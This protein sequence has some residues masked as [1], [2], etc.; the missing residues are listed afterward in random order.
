[1]NE[2]ALAHLGAVGPNKRKERKKISLPVLITDMTF[3]FRNVSSMF[4]ASFRQ[5]TVSNV[6]ALPTRTSKFSS[7]CDFLN[8]HTTS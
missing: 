3:V 4:Y 5:T 1:V 7:K 2:E 6:Q 8:F